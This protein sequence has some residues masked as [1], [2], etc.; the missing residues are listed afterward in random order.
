MVT[1]ELLGAVFDFQLYFYSDHL[2]YY[3]FADEVESEFDYV[4]DFSVDTDVHV[5]ID[6]TGINVYLDNILIEALSSLLHSS[7]TQMKLEFSS[8]LDAGNPDLKEIAYYN[9]GALTPSQL[10]ALTTYS[11]VTVSEPP[12]LTTTLD[13]AKIT[14]DWTKPAEQEGY[15]ITSY[16]I[17]R[18]ESD[19]LLPIPDNLYDTIGDPN[20]LTYDDTELVSGH[21]YYYLV[22]AI[23]SVGNGLASNFDG[24]TFSA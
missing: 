1:F 15:N 21:S 7:A 17:Y 6:A 10:E 12:V 18:S 24:E 23:T 13:G 8:V 11:G 14:L 22:Q 9:E 19:T 20:V 5:K 2:H 3:V 16:K 4:Y